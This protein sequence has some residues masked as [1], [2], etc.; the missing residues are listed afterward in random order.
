MSSVPNQG[1]YGGPERPRGAGEWARMIAAYTVA[2]IFTGMALAFLFGAVIV[3]GGV[4]TLI[5]LL[6]A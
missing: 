6:I 4:M 3:I 1:E 5:E 2:S